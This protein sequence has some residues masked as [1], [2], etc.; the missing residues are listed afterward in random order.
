MLKGIQQT[1]QGLLFHF[2]QPKLT[3]QGIEVRV[4]SLKSAG[5]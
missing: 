4:N 1:N 3:V 5:V 2:K